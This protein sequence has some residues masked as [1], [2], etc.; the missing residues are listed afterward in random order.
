MD[1][2]DEREEERLRDAFKESNYEKLNRNSKESDNIHK[3]ILNSEDKAIYDYLKSILSYEVTENKNI[4]K[5]KVSK[6]A[7][8][9]IKFLEGRPERETVIG[10][11]DLINLRIALN[12]STFEKFL[13]SI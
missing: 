13:E 2:Y 6:V 11:D 1:F 5:P 3:N 9:K 4:S 7:G 10:G 8:K 12:S